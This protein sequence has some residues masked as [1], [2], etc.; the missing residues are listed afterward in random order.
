MS[1]EKK[2][3][4]MLSRASIGLLTLIILLVT[5]GAEPSAQSKIRAPFQVMADKPAIIEATHVARLIGSAMLDGTDSISD[6]AARFSTRRAMPRLD[7]LLQAKKFQLGMVTVTGY[8]ESEKDIRERTARGIIV[9]SDPYSRFMYTHFTVDYKILDN[10]SI[11]IQ[12][13][14]VRPIEPQLPR[15]IAFC[16]PANK[17]PQGIEKTYRDTE[18]LDYVIQNAVDV[19]GPAKTSRTVR[20]YVVFAFFMERLAEDAEIGLL[21]SDRVDDLSGDDKDI[22]TFQENGFHVAYAPLRFAVDG[23]SEVFFKALYTPGSHTPPEQRQSRLV[24]V[25]TSES[26]VKKIQ[27][28]LAERGYEPGPADGVMGDRTRQAIQQFQRDQK[29]VV[30]GQP[31]T[32]LLEILTLPGQPSAVTLAQLSLAVLGYDPGLADGIMGDRTRQAIQQFQRDQG[33]PPDGNLTVDLLEKMIVL[34]GRTLPAL[35]EGQPP[36]TQAVEETGPDV[37]KML[38]TKMWPNHVR[39]P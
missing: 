3:G 2:L 27:R 36:P 30:D 23:S 24:D 21:V 12:S 5:G 25:F 29:L 15:V 20:D 6:P 34:A 28:A 4:T 19:R 17:V 26:G 35:M 9:H 10:G 22:M 16:V 33:G 38:E 18:L 7:P 39:R 1:H 14:D 11:T 37:R 31:S 13:T 8:E 32:A